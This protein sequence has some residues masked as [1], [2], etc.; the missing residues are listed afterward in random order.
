MTDEQKPQDQ[1]QAEPGNAA[2]IG[3]KDQGPDKSTSEGTIPRARLNQEIEKRKQAETELQ[4]VAEAL[5]EDVPADFQAL[6][7]DLPPAAKIKWLREATAKGLFNP[8]GAEALDTKKPGD[9]PP[10]DYSKMTP[11]EMRQAGYK[12]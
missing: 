9:K 5:A 1:N 7:P 2:D 11:L 4:A 8:K 10:L 3:E 6:I 12:S